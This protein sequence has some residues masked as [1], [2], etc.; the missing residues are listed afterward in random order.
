MMLRSF[1]AA[2]ALLAAATLSPASSAAD[3]PEWI[4]TGDGVIQTTIAVIKLDVIA[5]G[6]DM[7]CLPA[8]RSKADV[9]SADCDKRLSWKL[10]RDVDK[11]TVQTSL[12]KAY[13]AVDYHDGARIERAVS[14]LSGDLPEGAR[15]TISFDAANQTT[16]FAPEHRPKVNVDGAAFMR[17]TWRTVFA[18]EDA[19]ELG[20]AL[21]AR[22]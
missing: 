4:H 3:Q 13:A 9:V 19:R 8:H 5:V 12:R 16:T 1:S 7:R 21:I 18:N 15:V 2:G 10:L 11:D 17:A 20:D 6:H 22:L 14:A